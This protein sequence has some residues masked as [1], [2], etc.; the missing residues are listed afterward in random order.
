VLR[1][2]KMRWVPG[3]GE[4]KNAYRL[5]CIRNKHLGD[6]DINERTIIKLTLK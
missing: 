6:K 5:S 3:T 4:M 1:P 2:K